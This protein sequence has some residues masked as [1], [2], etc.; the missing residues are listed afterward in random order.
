M[1]RSRVIAF[2]LI[3]EWV[4]SGGQLANSGLVAPISVTQLCGTAIG[5]DL[6]FIIGCDCLNCQAA[7][8]CKAEMPT[9]STCSLFRN[10]NEAERLV[11]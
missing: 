2:K 3:L 4:G 10:G 9:V 5:L 6:R 7:C 1:Q 8:T 11:L